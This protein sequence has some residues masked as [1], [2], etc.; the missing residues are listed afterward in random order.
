MTTLADK[1]RALQ[2]RL[3]KH[4]AT[5]RE[6]VEQDRAL[7]AIDNLADELP[8]LVIALAASHELLSRR[9]TD[10]IEDNHKLAEEVAALL[11]RIEERMK[12]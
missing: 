3:E 4:P 7:L 12:P 1:M 5:H 6:F 11:Q 2:A 8:A 9:A 10:P